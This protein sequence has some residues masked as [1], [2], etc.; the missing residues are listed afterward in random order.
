MLPTPPD[1]GNCSDKN[2]TP[3]NSTKLNKCQKAHFGLVDGAAAVCV[4]L[5]S[6]LP[7]AHYHFTSW[8]WCENIHFKARNKIT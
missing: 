1:C 7:A 4:G 8:S 6:R 5:S 2:R 3:R